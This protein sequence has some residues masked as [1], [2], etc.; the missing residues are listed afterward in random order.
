MRVQIGDIEGDV[1]VPRSAAQRWRI[2]SG[3][4]SSLGVGELENQVLMLTRCW[5]GDAPWP[6]QRQ[7]QSDADWIDEVVAC[8]E[9]HGATLTDIVGATA[10]LFVALN[11][12]GAIA[13]EEAESA[14]DFS[15]A[16]AE[17]S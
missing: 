5:I 3:G 16:P 15:E 11:G 13:M 4:W 6:A 12:G 9:S 8:L 2:I 17:D 10:P 1:E 14:A 7:G